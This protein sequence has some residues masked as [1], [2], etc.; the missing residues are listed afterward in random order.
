MAKRPMTNEEKLTHMMRF[1]N[2][3]AL[4]QCFIMEAVRKW[5]EVISRAAPEQ[6]ENGFIS[7]TAWIGVAKETLKEMSAEMT[8]NDPE[9]DDD[10]YAPSDDAL[11]SADCCDPLY[12]QRM[13]SADMGE[14]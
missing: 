4:K 6:V 13:D 2:Y 7:G 12:G 3:S 1:S 5:A 11:E 14:C 10:D 9:L 8:I